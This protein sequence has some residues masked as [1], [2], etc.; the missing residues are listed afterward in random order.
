M[1]SPGW[2]ADFVRLK[3]KH[4]NPIGPTVRHKT[5][6]LLL[7]FTLN[8]Y[9]TTRRDTRITSWYFRHVLKNEYDFEIKVPK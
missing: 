5:A 3:K 6:N 4:K 2:G 7:Y 9:I 8:L 1:I